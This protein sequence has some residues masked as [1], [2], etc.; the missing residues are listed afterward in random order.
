MNMQKKSSSGI[1]LIPLESCLLSDRT[2]FITGNIEEES[3][4]E[5]VKELMVLIREDDRAPIRIMINTAGGEIN[6]G[7]LIY[8]AIVSCQTPLEM[9][10]IGK[11]FSMGAVIFAAGRKGSRY[12]L[13]NSELMVHE[14]LIGN[15]VG[16]SSSSIQS[17]SRT[18]LET[19]KKLNSILV[20]H[21]GRTEE[22]VE[23]ATGYD[24]YFKAKEAITFGL[25]D[26]V[27]GFTEMVMGGANDRRHQGTL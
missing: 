7:M 4:I 8:D 6:S 24:H 19:K 1:T 3:A 27:I 22:E 13:E 10:C 11:A 12:M 14:P 17:I 21:T 15:Q 9:Y 25:A 26:H 2:I 16:G 5:F 18:L 20:K 23:Q